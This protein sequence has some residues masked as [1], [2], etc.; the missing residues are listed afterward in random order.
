MIGSLQCLL[1]LYRMK[2]LEVDAIKAQAVIGLAEEMN[3]Q[4]GGNTKSKVTADDIA[5]VGKW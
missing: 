1:V 2:S 4:S 5:F 3:K